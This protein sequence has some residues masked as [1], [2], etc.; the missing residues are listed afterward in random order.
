MSRSLRM[1]LGLL[2][3]ATFLVPARAGDAERLGTTAVP[4]SEDV[5]LRVDPD[6]T[7]YDGSVRITIEVRETTIGCA[8]TPRT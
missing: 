2:A 7:D 1:L 4:V 5:V 8:S 3:A 6:R